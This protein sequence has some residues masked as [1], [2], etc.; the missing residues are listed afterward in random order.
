MQ[1]KFFAPRRDRN[2]KALTIEEVVLVPGADPKE[3][4]EIEST[5]F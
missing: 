5:N 2:E 3:F 1:A 4:Y